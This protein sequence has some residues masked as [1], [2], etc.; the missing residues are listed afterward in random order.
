MSQGNTPGLLALSL[1]SFL[2][3]SFYC[4]D[5]ETV[6]PNYPKEVIMGPELQALINLFH[7]VQH[8]AFPICRQI[9][10]LILRSLAHA[11]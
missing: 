11:Q 5:Y 2:A 3:V 1:E 4:S 9:C 6:S 7:N 8:L 10:P